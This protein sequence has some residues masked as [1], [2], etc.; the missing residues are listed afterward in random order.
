MAMQR[1]AAA[2]LAAA[3]LILPVSCAS[4]SSP[5]P[6]AETAARAEITHASFGTAPTGEPVELY[7]LTNAHGMRVRAMSYGG[8]IQSLRVPDRN[9][10][11]DDVVLGFDDLAG[12][13]KDSPYFGAIIGR[14]GN[15][16]AHGTFTIDGN[17]YHVPIND[18]QNSLHGGIRGFDKVV[19]HVAPFENRDGQGL[20]FTHLSPDGDQGYPGNLNVKVTYTL[21]DRNELII[22]YEATTD[23]PTPINLTNHSYFNL[24]GE[25]HGNVLEHEVQIEASHYTPV[26]STLIPTG[27]IAPVEGTPFDFRRP[28]AIGARIN[29]PNQ[30]LRYAG[31]YD[32]NWVLDRTGPGVA[33]IAHVLEPTTGRTLD[34]YTTEPG[35]QFYTGN[36]LN[37]SVVGKSGHAYVHRGAFCLETQ[38]YPDSPNHPNFPSTIL[39]PGQT[40]HSRTVFAFNTAK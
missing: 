3:S 37:G 12:Y 22:D 35:V 11:F 25:G 34:V 19:W 40:Y 27:E 1:P 36:F 10:N 2:L 31:G 5:A 30:Q 21:N 14:Y 39:R 33:H 15:R 32:H 4:H 8:I 28:T 7:T 16:I 18:G 24:A 20:V 38:H 23:K 26:D 9:G 13:V 29:E 6:G 17:T